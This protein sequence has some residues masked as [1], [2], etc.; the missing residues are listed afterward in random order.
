MKIGFDIDGVIADQNLMD[1]C[2]INNMDKQRKLYYQI[3]MPQL[4]PYLF[5][6]MDDEIHF[7]TARTK[8]LTE[9]TLNWCKKFFPGITVH[10]T[11]IESWKSLLEWDKWIKEVA[12]RKASIINRLDLD[13]YFE[14]IPNVVYKLRKLCLHT[15]I[16]QY[17]GRLK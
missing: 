16:I 4:N 6:T 9:I 11:E 13:V 12:R 15:K 17:G 14:D 2:A 1:L 8:D 10:I 7:I 3:R 5:A